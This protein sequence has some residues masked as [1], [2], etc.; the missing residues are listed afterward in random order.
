[1]D[2][3]DDVPIICHETYKGHISHVKGRKCEWCKVD[4]TED[5]RSC[6]VCGIPIDWP[7]VQCESCVNAIAEAW[8]SGSDDA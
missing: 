6:S 1:M 2:A 3:Y 5:A 4:T 8:H 7:Q